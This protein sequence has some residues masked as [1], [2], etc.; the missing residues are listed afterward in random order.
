MKE[1]QPLM[2]SL[3][4]TAGQVP[5]GTHICQIYTDDDE[6]NDSLLKFLLSGLQAKERAACF[7]E[8]V[9]ERQ[10]NEFFSKNGLSFSEL[11]KEGAFALSGTRDIYF[12]NDYFDPDRMLNLLTEFHRQSVQ[13]GFVG[14]RAIGEML[15]EVQHIPGG[16][17]LLEYESRVSL[18]L[19]DVPVTSVCQYDARAFDG[20]T[21]M[22]VLK[23]HPHMVV[24]GAV[25]KNPFYIPPE[26]FLR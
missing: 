16:E 14:A 15:P 4:F 12:Q 3:G 10:M 7:S 19:K 24:R 17:R 6:R 1:A 8:K 25:I 21:I 23:V 9:D 18:L 26:E 20:A 5:A 13:S 22:D 11:A 2:V